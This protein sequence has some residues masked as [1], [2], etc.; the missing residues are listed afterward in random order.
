MT[1]DS[2]VAET[3]MPETLVIIYFNPSTSCMS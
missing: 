2:G 1:A 3:R